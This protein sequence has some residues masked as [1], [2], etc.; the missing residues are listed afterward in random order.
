MSF[1]D[2]FCL[3]SYSKHLQNLKTTQNKQKNHKAGR[4]A[5]NTELLTLFILSATKSSIRNKGTFQIPKR[6]AC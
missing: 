1:P 5:L 6:A 2:Q 3:F 4:K